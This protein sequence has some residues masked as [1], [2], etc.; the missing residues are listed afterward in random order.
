MTK[1]QINQYYKNL[2][3]LVSNDFEKHLLKACL[4]NL[5]DVD[6]KL[7]FNNFSSG[8]RELSRHILS[9]LAPDNEVLKCV[10]YKDETKISRQV[11]RG[12]KIKYAIQGGL[13]DKYIIKRGLDIETYK[14]SVLD[15]INLLN[16]Y[17]H[18]NEESF[19]ISDA[20]VLKLSNLVVSAFSN[21]INGINDC[22]NLI[23]VELEE[24]ID[25]V[26]IEHTIKE[27]IDDIDILS[28][29]HNIEYLQID[30]IKIVGITHDIINASADGNI[31]VHQ[32]F[33]SDGDVSRGD[34]VEWDTSFPFN[35]EIAISITYPLSKA[36]ILIKS[37]HVDTDD[38]YE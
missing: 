25:N 33:G 32:Q 27:N 21:F 8:I 16:K 13:N 35:G 30:T 22:R 3:H 23:I 28:T 15:A 5:L 34:G 4:N 14:K 36:E 29:H 1:T 2:E 19:G 9:T 38:W 6:N 11:T 18:V 24:D 12:Q 31:H 17:T 20:E 37:F 10:W 7:R 26:L